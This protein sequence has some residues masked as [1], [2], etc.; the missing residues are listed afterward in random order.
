MFKKIAVLTLAVLLGIVYAVDLGNPKRQK[1]SRE[2]VNDMTS[3]S[4]KLPYAGVQSPSF[5][6]SRNGYGWCLSTSRKIQV[7]N[8]AVY[9]TMLGAIYRQD[10]TSGSGA[11]GGMIGAWN[12]ALGADFEGYAQNIYSSSIYQ[13]GDGKPGGRYPYSCGFINGY[14]FGVFND[15]DNGPD[16]SGIAETSQPMFSVADATYGWDISF[17]SAPKRVEATEGGATVPAAW[18]GNGDVVYDPVS[19]YY[20]W[21]QIWNETLE[22]LTNAIADVVVGRS[23]TPGN[24]DSWV[25]TD[26]ND[27][28]FDGTDDTNGVTA[29]GDVYAAYCKDEEGV[30][31]GYG[32]IL[33]N[34]NDVD[35]YAP[36]SSGDDAL[37]N[38]KISWLYT[39]NWGGDDGSGD[40]AP[41]WIGPGDGKF[42]QLEGKDIFDWYGEQIITR[43]SIGV[44]E[45]GNIVW[46]TTEVI[47]IDDP[48]IQWNLSA[49]ATENNNVHLLIKVWPATLDAPDS[50]YLY[51]DNGLRGGTYH[52]K[53]HISDTGVT[54][55]K[56]NRVA[57]WVNFYKYLIGEQDDFEYKYYNGV[58]LSIGYAGMVND[59]EVIY[60]SWL[61]M[62]ESRAVLSPYGALEGNAIYYDDIYVNVSSDGG[63]SWD[64]TKENEI[65]WDVIDGDSI[66]T[67]EYYG[68]NISKT[69]T[70]HEDSWTC[71][72][73]GTIT[74][75]QLTF[76][77]GHQVWDPETLTVPEDDDFACYRQYL[78][79]WKI[80][81]TIPV[82]IEAEEVS[83]AKDFTLYQNYPNPFNPAT[84]IR[85][86]IQNDANIKLAVYNTKGEL[87][88]NLKNEK[89]VKGLHTVNFDASKF[90]SGVYF[91]KLSVDGRAETKKMVL[92][93]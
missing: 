30:G 43:D 22:N 67:Y 81:G 57:S 4:P 31:T 64:Y 75:D 61:D 8:D 45:F 33:A 17:W 55:G 20:Y 86:S 90:N 47:T 66:Y 19:G 82:G 58:N 40:W 32:I 14:F 46:D 9:G 13:T 49:V 23:L 51:T 16:G 79:A 92:T 25:W 41:N 7:N 77:G 53:G 59:Q 85:F 12:G 15:M 63:W 5:D 54:W 50:Y 73:Y 38:G 56:A 2:K 37:Q 3:F 91:Y 84:E 11:I 34:T 69:T 24:P 52:L 35:D 93:K 70:V 62:P 36:N 87:V 68:T 65:L 89:M 21:T 28:R 83:L 80:T 48:S 44:D 29:F 72:S 60:A 26:Y 18:T 71:A 27:L 88:S 78:K 1:I 10:H 42:F 39:T 76:Y 74:D 6:F